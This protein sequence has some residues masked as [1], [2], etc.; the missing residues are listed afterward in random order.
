MA[1]SDDAT[2]YRTREQQELLA[3]DNATDATIK[4]LHWEMA[5]RYAYLAQEAERSADAGGVTVSQ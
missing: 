1:R 3:S 5:Q 4:R 2:F